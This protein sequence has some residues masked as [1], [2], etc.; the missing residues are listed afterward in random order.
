MSRRCLILAGV[1]PPYGGAGALR[2]VKLLKYLPREGWQAE[3][4]AP[5]GRAGWFRDEALASEV[6]DVR[7]HRVGPPGLPR[8]A[9]GLRQAAKDPRRRGLGT[10][11]LGRVMRIARSV[12]DVIAIPDELG[13]WAVAA[14]R[15]AHTLLR[16]ASFDA[17][18]TTAFPYSA[19]LAGLALTRAGGPPWLVELRDPWS[20]NRFRGHGWAW[21]R[22][23]DELCERRVLAGASAVVVV[24][25]G[26][27]QMLE[28]R[29]G[30]LGGRLHLVTNGFDPDDFSA[31]AAPLAPDRLT[32][33]YVGTFDLPLQPPDTFLEALGLVLQREPTAPRRLRFRI[34]GGADLE[35]S[36]RIR[37]WMEKHGAKGLVQI[38]PFVAHGEA[39]EAMQTADALALS[40]AD[41]SPWVLTSKV[42]EYLGSGRPILAVVPRGDCRDLLLRCGGATLARPGDPGPLA[43]AIL[44]AFARGR[45]ETELP[46][47]DAAVSEYSHR[48]IAARL[49]AILDS[50]TR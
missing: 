42:F 28:A 50:I 13:P 5:R 46:R 19:H 6:G 18:F 8:V 20:D 48:R 12:R 33:M 40:V 16:G 41:D 7:I 38:D 2:M 47:D 15:K 39:L 45:F 10:A 34:L 37:A 11:S 21:R 30:D 43:N 1:F 26:M 25:P 23:L 17:L 27:R 9:A 14:L 4:V 36:R 35:S 22:Q 32:V 49:A 29:F 44:E 31:G 3:V 24:T